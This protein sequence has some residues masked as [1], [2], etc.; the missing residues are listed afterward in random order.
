MLTSWAVPKGP[1]YNPKDKRFAALVED[2]PLDCADFEGRIPDGNYGAGHVIIWDRGT[3]NPLNKVANGLERGKLLFELNGHKMKGRWTLVRMK[4]ANEWLL[5][6]EHDAWVRDD[7]GDFENDSVVSGLTLETIV[8]PG[9]LQKKVRARL[10]RMRNVSAHAPI[11]TRPMLATA[12]ELYDRRDWIYEFKYDGYR[13]LGERNGTSVVLRSRNGH[14][15]TAGFPEIA[16][17]IA[18][19]PYDQFVVD[20]ELIAVDPVGRPSFSLL[21]Q[22]ARLRSETEISRAAI[23]RPCTYYAFDLLQ[24]CGFDVR[25]LPLTRRKQLLQPLLPSRGPVRYS[26]HVTEH[27]KRLFE[28][29]RS[30]GV[31][32][33]VAKQASAPYRAGR[34]SAWIKVRHQKTDDFVVVGF[35]TSRGS[36]DDLGSLAL[37]EY[38]NQTLTYVGRVGS[39]F[40]TSERGELKK[41]ID[42]CPDLPPLA[43]SS[44]T[45]WKRTD[46]VAEVQFTEYTLDGHLRH[47]VF[48]R[49][50]DDKS[51]ADCQGQ[52]DDP[53]VGQIEPAGKPEVVVTNPDKVFF[54]EKELTKKHLVSYYEKIAP[55][56]LPYLRNRPIVLTRFPDGIHGKSFYQRDAPDFVPDWIDRTT[57]WSDSTDREVNYFVANDATVLKYLANMGTIPIHVWHSRLDDLEHP[58]W[59]VLDLD[60]KDAPFADVVTVALGIGELCDELSLPAFPKTSGASG[61]HILIPLD[62]QLTHV[63]ARDLGELLARVIVNRYPVIATTAR[64][65][66]RRRGR[67]YIDYLQNGHGRLI[68]A[69]FSA[70]AEPAASVSMPV[71][72]HE[73]NGRLR[74]ER[75]HISNAPARMKRLGADPLAGVLTER[76][77]LARSLKLLAERLA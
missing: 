46:L 2:H 29:A 34:S 13:I 8:E 76:G 56:M 60:P 73:V 70:R 43:D 38:R 16:Q 41:R 9:V 33:V 15:L 61:L 44:K 14:D 17:S 3:W 66:A 71:G 5:I 72:W 51:P 69:P 64:T 67:V 12:G 11:T 48:V 54:P 7:A 65:V 20:G 39:G 30:L 25:N 32:G 53:D 63:Q 77:D 50:R 47:P 1:S 74:N 36:G 40:T 24:L 31:E 68:A 52:Y 49:L 28:T 18:R 62:N 27:G 23:E 10:A 22:R 55:W 57:L 21:Q 19:L 35:T 6:K 58:D 45:V 75:F 59:L 42:D 4:K 26:E 37:A